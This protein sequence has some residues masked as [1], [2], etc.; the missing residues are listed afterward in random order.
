MTEQADVEL[1]HGVL[2]SS[3]AGAPSAFPLE[4]SAILG[5]EDALE[6]LEFAAVLDRVAAFAVGPLGAESVRRRRPVTDVPWIQ[7]E[8]GRVEEL[9][10][11]VRAVEVTTGLSDSQFTEMVSGTLKKSDV[12]VTGVQATPVGPPR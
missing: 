1:P 9:T 3:D 10:A 4:E 2:V 8:L 5:S 7:A 11:L 12:L 6:A